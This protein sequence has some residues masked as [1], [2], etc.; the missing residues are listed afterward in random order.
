MPDETDYDARDESVRA[1]IVAAL[2]SK[3]EQAQQLR[4]DATDLDIEAA[5]LRANEYLAPTSEE[6]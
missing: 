2:Q 5:T 4:D 1:R 6:S 3:R